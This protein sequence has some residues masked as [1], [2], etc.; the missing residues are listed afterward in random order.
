MFHVS[1]SSGSHQHRIQS[2]RE[3]CLGH[4]PTGDKRQY[5]TD[6]MPWSSD[7]LL[8]LVKRAIWFPSQA[9]I[10]SVS[11][12]PSPPP[13]SEKPDSQVREYPNG[14]NLISPHSV[15]NVSVFKMYIYFFLVFRPHENNR[16]WTEKAEIFKNTAALSGDLED[17]NITLTSENQ[18]RFDFVFMWTTTQ[19]AGNRFWKMVTWNHWIR[20]LQKRQ[21]Q[22]VS[23]FD[24]WIVKIDGNVQVWM[25][26]ILKTGA[27]ERGLTYRTI[28]RQKNKAAVK[29]SQ[30]QPDVKVWSR[31][32]SEHSHW[33]LG[34]TIL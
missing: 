33:P 20:S 9:T 31:L 29:H 34:L 5:N 19:T 27:C 23:I 26:N 10:V 15:R 1:C 12:L 6:L 4:Q 25:K 32:Y 8:L 14:P 16:K 2:A 7:V 24:V 3:Q 30:L 21:F 17:G 28:E 18:R 11:Y 22:T 13:Y